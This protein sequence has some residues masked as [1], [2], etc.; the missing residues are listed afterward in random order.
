MSCPFL[1]FNLKKLPTGGDFLF[2][3]K[4]KLEKKR[5]WSNG[6]GVEGPNDFF[7]IK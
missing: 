3:I 7:G 4:F 5:S 2:D 6:D 1:F